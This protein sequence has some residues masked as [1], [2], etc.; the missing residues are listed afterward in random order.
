MMCDE[1]KKSFFRVGCKGHQKRCIA[2]NQYVC[3]YH[4][5]PTFVAIGGHE[6]CS[7][8]CHTSEHTRVNC[9]GHLENCPG[10]KK[11]YCGYHAQQANI[12]QLVGGHLCLDNCCEID[13][14]YRQNCKGLIAR[15]QSCN[16]NHCSYHSTPN[17]FVG[18]HDCVGT[19]KCQ[20]TA[21]Y[22]RNCTGGAVQ[23]PYCPE[24]YCSYHLHPVDHILVP[25]GGHVCSGMTADVKMIKDMKD[26]LV[27]LF[28][29]VSYNEVMVE[30]DQAL[31][32]QISRIQIM[33]EKNGSIRKVLR[34]LAP[35]L[36]A[37]T[38]SKV[39]NAAL[40]ILT[41]QLIRVSMRLVFNTFSNPREMFAEFA[42]AAN[43]IDDV[44]FN[45]FLMTIHNDPHLAFVKQILAD[46]Q[47]LIAS[48]ISDTTLAAL[49]G[50]QTPN[51]I[52]EVCKMGGEDIVTFSSVYS[53][54]TS[55]VAVENSRWVIFTSVIQQDK[56]LHE[57]LILILK[58]N[59]CIGTNSNTVLA[60]IVA[61][62][63]HSIVYNVFCLFIKYIL[64]LGFV[65][66]RQDMNTFIGGGYFFPILFFI[67]MIIAIMMPIL[68]IIEVALASLYRVA[69]FAILGG[70]CYY[71]V[72][73]YHVVGHL[74]PA[75]R[76][77]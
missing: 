47:P 49:L 5:A 39:L 14:I 25:T 30:D 43:S 54:S 21:I 51:V 41:P 36:S 34:Q 12:G 8:K 1:K 62:E 23:C 71:G 17:R 68:R 42:I 18:G 37:A 67:S 52:R 7:S 61:A 58:T 28:D 75:R 77:A 72:R 22:Q 76:A 66:L 20:T 63:K 70:A 35:Q 15:C 26:I 10:C 6:G 13:L 59:Y 45:D 48:M 55:I 50:I 53:L 32:D 73:H 40:R 24:M 69:G 19:P 33:Q 3:K 31:R 38:T 56:T 16:K 44:L 2:C 60:A 4:G 65:L 9:E 57:Q 27:F 64:S 46:N 11:H 74:I 29:V